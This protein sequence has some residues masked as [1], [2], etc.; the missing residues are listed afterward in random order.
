MDPQDREAYLNLIND[1]MAKVTSIFMLQ[2]M[3]FPMMINQND[4]DWSF[5]CL[6]Q[7]THL[8]IIRQ[9]AEKKMVFFILVKCTILTLAP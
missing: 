2:L 3:V 8:Q 6:L 9:M 1:L 7:V 5:H 4:Q